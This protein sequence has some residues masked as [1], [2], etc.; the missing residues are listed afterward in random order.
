M[1]LVLVAEIV[2]TLT[3]NLVDM[4]T[5]GK[6]DIRAKKIKDLAAGGVLLSAL[7]AAV[8]GIVIFANKIW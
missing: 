7:F 8:I 4:Y 6:Y 2:N 3:E 5:K 1:V